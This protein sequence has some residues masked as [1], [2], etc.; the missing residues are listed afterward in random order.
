MGGIGEALVMLIG[1]GVAEALRFAYALSYLMPAGAVV[2]GAAVLAGV[3]GAT[4]LRRL[5][6]SEPPAVRPAAPVRWVLGAAI[7]ATA[8][9]SGGAEASVLCRKGDSARLVLR[10]EAC[11]AHEHAVTAHEVGL[12]GG[13]TC[14]E[15]VVLAWTELDLLRRQLASV[16]DLAERA[17]EISWDAA[18][19]W[20]MLEAV[21]IVQTLDRLHDLATGLGAAPAAEAIAGIRR[22]VTS[23]WSHPAA[24]CAGALA[25]LPALEATLPLLPEG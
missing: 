14:V 18:E 13:A 16:Q 24:A 1:N 9:A 11:R 25:M 12:D 8:L 17:E 3:L 10:A 7:V 21:Q 6:G 15:R 2:G 23:E 5:H 19:T 4:A 22:Q 20:L